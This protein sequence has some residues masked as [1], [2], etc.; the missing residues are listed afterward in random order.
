M[1]DET[2]RI[3]I[4]AE[5][6]RQQKEAFALIKNQVSQKIRVSE[7]SLAALAIAQFVSRY[8]LD[9]QSVLRDLS[10]D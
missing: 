3:T 7:A 9:P 4:V 8:S 2:K 10:D 1:S 5:V 6:T